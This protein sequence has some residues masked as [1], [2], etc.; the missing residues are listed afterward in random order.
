M[1]ISKI[2]EVI[3]RLDEITQHCISSQNRMGYFAALYKRMT[4]AVSEAILG[5]TFEDGER[6]N[7][8]DVVFAQ[9]YLDAFDAYNSGNSC[10]TA[11]KF[12]FDCCKANDLIVI[13]H[14]LLGINTHIN[15]DLAIASATV[16]PGDAINEIA[17][18]FYRINSIIASLVDDIQ[19]SLSRVWLPMRLL[20]KIANGRE[21]A[22][23]NFSIDKARETSWCNALL[24]AAM[25]KGQQD[26]YIQQMDQVVYKLAQGIRSPG[27]LAA[28]LVKTI[29]TTEY[30]NIARTIRL[31]DTSV[32][33]A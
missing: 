30:S 25:D 12:T 31:I 27:P 11:W 29:H 22:V 8:L 28:M 21:K 20:G 17:N 13:Q 24:L 19:E 14:L 1:L 10:S 33:V 5:Q 15:L 4:V 2:D 6:M 23:L 26:A 32:A 18:D 7:H 16:A 3:T 9:R